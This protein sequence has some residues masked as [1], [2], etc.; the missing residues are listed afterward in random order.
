MARRGLRQGVAV[1]SRSQKHTRRGQHMKF[2]RVYYT[3]MVQ[4]ER[5]RLVWH[6]YAQEAW[7]LYGAFREFADVLVVEEG[8]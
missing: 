7:E 2:F 8:A 3:A 4:A 1:L 6:G 5:T